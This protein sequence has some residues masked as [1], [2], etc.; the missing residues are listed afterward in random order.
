[1]VAATKIF[2]FLD[3]TYVGRKLELCTIECPEFSGLLT[4]WCESN[5]KKTKKAERQEVFEFQV[6]SILG[7]VYYYKARPMA[8]YDKESIIGTTI[9]ITDITDEKEMLLELERRARIDEVTGILNR[10]YFI[11]LANMEFGK[12]IQQSENG[13]MVMFDIDHFKQIN[14]SYGHQAGDFILKELAD[15]TAGIIRNNDLLGRYGGEEYIIFLPGLTVDNGKLVVERIRAAFEQ[16][17]FLF[18]QKAIQVTASFGIT[19][20]Y[21]LEDNCYCSFDEMIKKVD[22]GLYQA[23][24]NGRNQIVVC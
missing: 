16:H 1:N 15:I 18:E 4:C 20:Y 2:K 3:R 6:S 7:E 10:R 5:L 12:L 14:D 21:K 11:E 22:R 8:L 9:L 19:Q 24:K 17:T 23:K 13:I